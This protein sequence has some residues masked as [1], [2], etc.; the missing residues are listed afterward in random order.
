MG[1][2]SRLRGV[3]LSSQPRLEMPDVVP[4]WVGLPLA[5]YYKMLTLVST[6][7]LMQVQVQ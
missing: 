3:C 2:E 7:L 4:M 6:E 1:V 5:S